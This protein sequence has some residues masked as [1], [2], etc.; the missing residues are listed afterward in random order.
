[1]TYLMLSQDALNVPQHQVS[2]AVYLTALCGNSVCQIFL[3]FGI[4]VILC[5]ESY[6]PRSNFTKKSAT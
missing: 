3:K 2:D 1:V 5:T 4:R 6:R